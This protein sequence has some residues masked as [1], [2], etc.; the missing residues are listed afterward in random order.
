MVSPGIIN[1]EGFSIFSLSASVFIHILIVLA[2]GFLIKFFGEDFPADSAYIQV[3]TSQIENEINIPENAEKDLY[4]SENKIETKAAN[5]SSF[6]DINNLSAD[7]AQLLQTYK[8]SSL[9]VRIK[10][11]PGWTYI[12]QNVKNKLD[13]VTFW[14][15]AGTFNPPPYIHL[16]VKEKYLFNPE[17]FKYKIKINDYTAYFNDPEELAGQ[18]SQVI[19]LRTDSDED[20]S[21]KLIMT[22]Q[23]SF[24]SFQPMFF[25]MLKTFK[26]GKSFF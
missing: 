8:E 20:Y 11:P 7:T 10:Y 24:Y 18:F 15:S 2:A 13:G 1:K 26:F 22:G 3:E 6:I 16:E 12:D 19:Y 25:A 5:H 14:S 4:A 9:N 23:E 21:L 17:R